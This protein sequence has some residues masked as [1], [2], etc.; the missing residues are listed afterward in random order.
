MKIYFQD[1]IV[2]QKGLRIYHGESTAMTRLKTV[3]ISKHNSNCFKHLFEFSEKF[4]VVHAEENAILNANGKD[5]DG[6][7][8]FCTLF[9]CYQCARLIVKVCFF[10]KNR[11]AAN[12]RLSGCVSVNVYLS[13]PDKCF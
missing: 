2:C 11:D 5:L 4:F 7:T 3:K 12:K 1:L 10:H 8:M 13:F 6:T 9:P